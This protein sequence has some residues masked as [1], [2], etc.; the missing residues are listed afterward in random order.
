MDQKQATP[1]VSIL[2]RP[3]GLFAY[4]VD[5]RE[6]FEIPAAK[7][8]EA[9]LQALDPYLERIIPL[10]DLPQG[11]TG[12]LGSALRSWE[13]LESIQQFD[14]AVLAHLVNVLIHSLPE[15][16]AAKTPAPLVFP[17]EPPVFRPTAAN[18]RAYRG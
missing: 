5:R 11:T 12:R 16:A 9:D 10:R 17:P 2:R 14:G 7:A 18:P 6:R 13:A 8:S 3:D 15:D 4:L 1:F